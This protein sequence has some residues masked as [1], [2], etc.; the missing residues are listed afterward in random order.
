M[1]AQ[2]RDFAR[3]NLQVPPGAY[4]QTYMR[5]LIGSIERLLRSRLGA[6]EQPGYWGS[7]YT[8]VNGTAVA[9]AIAVTTDTVVQFDTLVA[10]H[11][12]LVEFRP[13][14]FD[15]V[16]APAGDLTLMTQ[17]RTSGTT[18]TCL[19]KVRRNGAV[20]MALNLPVRTGGDLVTSFPIRAAAGDV[21]DVMVNVSNAQNLDL[22]QSACVLTRVSPDPRFSE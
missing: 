9:Q 5:G 19:V 1:P 13:S 16:V 22:T 18:G 11:D 4:D 7:A 17:I 20:A 14:T 21:L 2:S 3:M 15:F 6:G 8:R 12:S 10:S